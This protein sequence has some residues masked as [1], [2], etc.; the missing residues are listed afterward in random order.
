LGAGTAALG[1]IACAACHGASAVVTDLPEVLKLTRRTLT[2]NKKTIE[3]VGGSVSSC[4]L[5]WGE[6]LPARL[7]S[8]SFDLILGADILYRNEF[9]SE[10]L[11]TL[12]D[13]SNRTLNA[14]TIL[15]SETGT[16]GNHESQAN[17]HGRNLLSAAEALPP[18]AIDSS[19]SPPVSLPGAPPPLALTPLMYPRILLTFQVR[20]PEEEAAFFV[21]AQELGF[22]VSELGLS[23]LPML[24][25]W[26]QTHER[27]VE[28]TWRG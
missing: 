3:R 24:T 1:G 28:L 23:D 16:P 12:R 14:L 7:S 9:H 18:T 17:D 4:P 6:K 10:L 5:T 26:H 13:L 27:L 22:A 21:Q 25:A 8:N 2:H 19:S 20:H 15:K 11:Q